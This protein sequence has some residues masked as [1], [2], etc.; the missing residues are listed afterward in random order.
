MERPAKGFKL[1]VAIGYPFIDYAPIP[2]NFGFGPGKFDWAMK[3][4][5]FMLRD[6]NEIRCN[7]DFAA[8]AR[9]AKVFDFGKYIPCPLYGGAAALHTLSLGAFDA[10]RFHDWMDGAM[11]AQHARVHQALMEGAAKVFAEWVRTA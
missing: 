6:N 10:Q 7:M 8:G 9:P 5:S 4:F 11:V 3:L 1:E 2:N